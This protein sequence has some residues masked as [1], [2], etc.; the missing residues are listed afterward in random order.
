MEYEAMMEALRPGKHAHLVGIG[1]VSMCA[2]GE[3]LHG[4][5]VRVTGSDMKESAAVEHLREVG[6]P[7]VI[8]HVG[9]SVKGADC[10][11]RTA[12]VRDDNPEIVAAH[13]AGIP[14]YERAQAWG[15]LMRKY[16]NAICIAGTHGK[17]TTTSMTTHIFMEAHADP[18]VMI[19]GTLPLLGAGHRVGKGDTIILESCEYRNSFLSFSPT[20]AVILNVEADHLDFFKDLEDIQQSFRTFA[21]QTPA[22]TGVVVVNRDDA[23][24]M[25]SVRGIPRRMLTFG[26][27]P[28][29]DVYC[30]DLRMEENLPVFDV[31][32]RGQRYARVALCVPGQHNIY[33]A[34]AAAA[35]AVALGISGDAIEAGLKGFHGSERRFQYRGTYRGAR[36]YDDYAH[37]PSEL[38]ALLQA[39][40]ALPYDRVVC[41]FQPHT[42]TRTK[43]FFDDFVKELQGADVILLAEIYAAREQNT[44]GISAKDV[45][46][47]IPGSRY[48]PTLEEL[49]EHLREIAKPGDLIL[50]VG[51]GDIYT[52]GEALVDETKQN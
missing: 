33:N 20:V 28:T 25:E 24:A 5:G 41:A 15:A 51:A 19:G 44:V 36:V 49:T 52:V 6:V 8:G 1:G 27:E 3:V 30:A 45:A 18:T 2:L 26:M 34:L 4:A 17:T 40:K 50:T 7:V 43:A 23:G 37:H 14:V 22:Q 46:A 38:H 21:L 29:A 47:R 16:R 39:A 31:M 12:A 9:E 13:E 35:V 42:Y 48:F 32:Y 10:V 11:I